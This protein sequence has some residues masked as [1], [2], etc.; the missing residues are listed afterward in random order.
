[1]LPRRRQPKRSGIQRA[2]RRV[3]A[4][5][6]AYVRRHE[7]A[8]PNCPYHDDPIEFSHLDDENSKGM[9]I[10]SPDWQG[11]SWC[12]THHRRAH[13]IGHEAMC[14]ENSTT[15]EAQRKI[16]AEYARTT[17]DKAMRAEMQAW[18]IAA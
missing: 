18:G 4:V 2:P 11:T 1:M 10:K 14:A 9:G 15:M 17:P 6:R 12:R 16:A 8:I 5:H 3:F 7:C 13:D